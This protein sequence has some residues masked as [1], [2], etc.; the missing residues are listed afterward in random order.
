MIKKAS[1]VSFYGLIIALIGVVILRNKLTIRP[2]V[3]GL[4]FIPLS[5]LFFAKRSFKA[6]I[7][8]LIFGA[9]YTG[10]LTILALWGGVVFGVAG[11]IAGGVIGDCL[12]D[13]I[14]VSLRGV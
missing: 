5:G 2:I 6:A 1:Y 3:L 11:A 13:E 8:D 10:L 7:P 4:T 12:T 9:I 14:A